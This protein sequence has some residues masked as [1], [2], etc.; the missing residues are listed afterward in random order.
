M[1]VPQLALNY[2]DG[3]QPQAIQATTNFV[4][5]SPRRIGPLARLCSPT[6]LTITIAPSAKPP[7]PYAILMAISICLE[8]MPNIIA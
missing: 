7:K 5:I 3:R 6:L 2:R 8:K 1:I 4:L